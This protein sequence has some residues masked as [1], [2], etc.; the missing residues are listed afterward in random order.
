MI[1]E[2][3]PVY[4]GYASQYGHGLGNVLGGLIRAALPT[5]SKIAK[6]AGTKLLDSGVQYVAKQVRKKTGT[7]KSRRV[8]RTIS[9]PKHMNKSRVPPGRAV[10]KKRVTKRKTQRD[11]FAK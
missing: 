9:Q 6:S 10:K 5:V 1:G 4:R 7:R 3:M 11:I 2:G 8:K